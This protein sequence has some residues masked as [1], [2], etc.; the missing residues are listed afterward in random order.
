MTESVCYM[1][2]I[3]IFH[4]DCVKGSMR[5]KFNATNDTVTMNIL[6]LLK[7]VGNARPGESDWH[8]IIDPLSI[9]FTVGYVNKIICEDN[10][11]SM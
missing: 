11:W 1:W 9:L 2:W 6:L 4:T 3:E 8:P 10:Y 7:M 5:R